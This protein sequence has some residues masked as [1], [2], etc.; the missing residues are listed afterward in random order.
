MSG[1]LGNFDP[2]CPLDNLIGNPIGQHSVSELMSGCG[3]ELLFTILHVATSCRL[4]RWF[5]LALA[6]GIC[7]W[8]GGSIFQDR[9]LAVGISAVLGIWLILEVVFAFLALKDGYD[10]GEFWLGYP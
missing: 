2:L 3:I 9:S 10:E 5:L 8:Q 1:I 7:I 6:C 4:G